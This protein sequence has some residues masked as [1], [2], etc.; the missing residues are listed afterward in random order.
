MYN[1]RITRLGLLLPV[2]DRHFPSQ[3]NTF[4]HST[5]VIYSHRN[6]K[7]T[8]IPNLQFTTSFGLL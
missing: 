4:K 7:F 2:Q 8:N 6:P 5:H 1:Q 3:V